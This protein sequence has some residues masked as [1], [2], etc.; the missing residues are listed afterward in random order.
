MQ[1]QIIDK[2]LKL[3]VVDAFHVAREANMG[4]RINTI[5][6]TCFFKLAGVI[7]ADEAIAQIK[8]AIK[9]TYG[10]KGGEKVITQNNAAVDAALASL[11]EVKCPVAVTSKLHMVPP[12]PAHAPAFVKDVL[13]M[14]IAN[15]GD[16]LPVGALPC[17]GTFPTAT[18]QYEKRSIAQ[19]IP[20]W[21]SKICIQ[22]GQCSLVCPHASIRMKAFDPALLAVA[23]KGFPTTDYK[24]KEFPGW[25]LTVQVLPDDCTGCGLCVEACPAKDKEKANHKAINLEP[26]LPHLDQQRANFDFFAAIP[27]V[28]RSKV[29]QDTIKGSQLLLPLF[30]FSGACAGCGET[31]YVKLITQ[32]FGDRMLIGNAT[33]CSSIYGGNLPCTPYAVNREGRGPSW[34]NSLFEDCAEFGFG[35]RLAIDQ[36]I[37]YAG[38]LLRRLAGQLGEELVGALLN[39]KQETEEDIAA[40][41]VRVADLNK[42]LA[43]IGSQEAKNLIASSDYLIRKSVWSFGGDGWAY[44]IGFGGLDHVFASSRD[45]NILVLDTEVYSNT[46][47]Q[48]SKS[49]F[50]GA[51]AKFAA[52]GKPSRKKDL[53]M[54]AMSYGNVFVGSIALGANPMHALRTI[55]AAES[56][57]GT[58]LLI[59][60]SHCINWGIDM[61]Q[62]MGI[63]K[64]AVACGYWPLYSF[65]PRNE[66]HPFQLASKKPEGAFKD[67]A[68]KEARFRILER[69][70]PEE[71]A[72]LLALGQQDIDAR[73]HYYEQLAGVDRNP[74]AGKD[75]G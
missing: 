75:N 55:R 74:E 19:D 61:Q 34:S 17:D 30:E 36:Q 18:T 13:G 58:S 50:R 60:F 38:E 35:F 56:Y 46:G 16:D 71:S 21:D 51:V 48:A 23:P 53:G 14:M 49:T 26:K 63:Q 27:D 69:S 72:K 62:G 65:D 10:K 2:K 28:D 20:I 39:N 42:R 40:Q 29:K 32:F 25:K 59:A 22:C 52:G 24:G 68:L 33:G 47:G 4:V 41:R 31:P 5:M 44:D 6:Q 8:D 11:H 3:F 12:V 67:F 43:A 70:K 37:D 54:I 57:R 64:D 9:K 15:C 1:K 7:P 45:V 66:S 73:Y